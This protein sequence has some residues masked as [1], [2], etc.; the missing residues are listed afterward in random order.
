MAKDGDPLPKT[1]ELDIWLDFTGINCRCRIPH[2]KDFHEHDGMKPNHRKKPAL[3]W[4]RN[5]AMW[6]Y[7]PRPPCLTGTVIKNLLPSL[8]NTGSSF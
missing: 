3:T 1:S 6:L 2:E 5:I 7:S 4:T 8:E